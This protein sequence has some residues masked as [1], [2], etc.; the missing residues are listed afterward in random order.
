VAYSKSL[1]KYLHV[2]SEEKFRDD[3]RAKILTRDLPSN[4]KKTLW[5][6][7]QCFVL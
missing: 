3:I 5:H 1:F 7:V 6:S 2:V 4:V